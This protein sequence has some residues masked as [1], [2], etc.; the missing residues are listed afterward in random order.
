MGDGD[1]YPVPVHNLL[2]SGYLMRRMQSFDSL[3]ATPSTAIKAGYF[4]TPGSEETTHYSLVDPAGNALSVTT[5]LNGAFGSKV[6][7][8]GA[9]FLLNNEM[10]DFS[11]KPGVPNMYGAVGGEANAVAP[12]KRPLSSM[13][14]TIVEKAGALYMVVGTPGG[15][16]IP[17]SVFQVTANVLLFGMGMQ[18]AIN[19][20]RFHHQWLPDVVFVEEEAFSPSTRQRLTDRGYILQNREPIGRVEGILR[21]PDGRLEG[22]AD[23]RGDD[24]AAGF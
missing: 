7:V 18:E 16:T 11:I 24:T 20:P 22:A 2:D 21:L 17:T 14:P 5:T 6:V 15:T 8:A 1:F 12:G 19:A 3:H 23:P 10:D 9:G 4:T 13:T